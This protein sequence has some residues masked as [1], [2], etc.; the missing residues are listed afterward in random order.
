MLM[1]SAVKVGS[2][3]AIK[4]DGSKFGGPFNKYV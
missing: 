4:F 1:S 3:G 2:V